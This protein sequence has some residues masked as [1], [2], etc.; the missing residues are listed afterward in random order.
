MSITV[1]TLTGL[2]FNL[3]VNSSDT[4]E[5]VKIKVQAA[6]GLPPN[7]QTLFSPTHERLEDGHTLS[8][9]K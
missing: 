7:V 6:K 8:E 1:K 3:Q 5:E 2:T 9:Y 4:I